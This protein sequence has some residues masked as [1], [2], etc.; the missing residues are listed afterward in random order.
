MSDNE[1]KTIIRR[2]VDESIGS[3]F[4][5]LRKRIDKFGVTQPNI[6][7]VGESGRILVELPGAKDVDRIKKLLQST[8]QLEFWE[9]YK[10]DEVGNFLMAANN[11]LKLTEKSAVEV[12][13]T[14]KTGI[15]T[16]LTAKSKD[17]VA[18]AKGNNPLLDKFVGQGGG[19]VLGVVSPKDTAAINGYLK[20]QDIRVLL[21][22]NLRYAKFVWG[23]P[24]SIVDEKTKKEIETVELYALKGNRDNQAA[25]SGG[26]VTDAKDSFD[27]LGKP[28]VTMQMSGQGAKAWEE[29]TGRAFTQKSNIAIVLD[30]VVYSAPGVS[31]G[32]ISGGRSEISGVF[33]VT[34]TKDLAN[35][36]RA[37]KLPAAAEII[38]SAE[39]GPSLGQKA[40]DAG[41][42]SSLVGFIL[43]C[44]WMVFYYGRAGWY[45][46][47]A[48]LLNVLFLFGV[49]AS[50]G[51]V[52]T[53]PGIA[54][55]V[56]TLGTAVDAN[57]I[58]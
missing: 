54:G 29:L 3:A 11:A 56:L 31:S 19:P 21:A 4:E 32:P 49:M 30:D 37:G 50:F 58:I 15:D 28:S 9:T 14:A 46:N 10:I 42:T 33:D 25:M 35:V 26:V 48:L 6:Q 18:P 36:L 43:V 5:V 38:Q 8:A 12:K 23:K 55:I 47:A 7:K 40:I 17:T 24:S 27:Q 22:A 53:L 44:V 45:A 51:F 2:K 16:L 39:V 34:E 1:V 20:R 41:I 57:I 13:E 52:L